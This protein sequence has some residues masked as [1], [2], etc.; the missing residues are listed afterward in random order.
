MRKQNSGWGTG[1]HYEVFGE[2]RV[3]RRAQTEGGREGG[4]DGERE[5]LYVGRE[6]LNGRKNLRRGERERAK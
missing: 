3:R 4:E 6:Q 1:S 5:E 2:L